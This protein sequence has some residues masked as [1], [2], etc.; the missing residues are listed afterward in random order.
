MCTFSIYRHYLLV[1]STVPA[2]EIF[3]HFP[4]AGVIYWFCQQFLQTENLHIFYLQAIFA[5]SVQFV[6]MEYVFAFSSYIFLLQ[7]SFAGCVNSF[8]K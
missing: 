8:C 5:G 7:A 4:F 6:Q 2:N 3:A 1:L